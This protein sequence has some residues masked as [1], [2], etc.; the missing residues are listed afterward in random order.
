M[1]RTELELLVAPAFLRIEP[2]RPAHH[3]GRFPLEPRPD[4]RV[5]EGIGVA[6][7]LQVAP[8]ECWIRPSADTLDCLAKVAPSRQKQKLS[9]AIVISWMT[10]Y[11]LPRKHG[12][13]PIHHTL[14]MARVTRPTSH[15]STARRKLSSGD[16][17]LIILELGLTKID[18]SNDGG[19]TSIICRFKGK[20]AL[21]FPLESRGSHESSASIQIFP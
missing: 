20:S 8:S 6:Q 12:R 9:R 2:H 21:F 18:S 1:L 4:V 15:G 19:R 5:Q 16:A 13:N 14:S 11:Y 7:D 17:H 3:V 10:H